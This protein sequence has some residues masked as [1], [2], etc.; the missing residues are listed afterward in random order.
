M[1]I[2][3]K[4]QNIKVCNLKNRQVYDQSGILGERKK[5]K[6]G[7]GNI[8]IIFQMALFFYPQSEKAFLFF[9]PLLFRDS[10]LYTFMSQPSYTNY[11]FNNT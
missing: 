9:F 7:E 2:I 1:Y 11:I 5:T 4:S 3:T 10:F 6:L 8:H